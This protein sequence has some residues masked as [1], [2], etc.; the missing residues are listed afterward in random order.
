MDLIVGMPKKAQ[1]SM[2]LI[3]CKLKK[4]HKYGFDFCK[5]KNKKKLN[6]IF[7][8]PKKAKKT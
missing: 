6:L 4:A 7:S 5:H 2:N 8:K 1:K 3:F